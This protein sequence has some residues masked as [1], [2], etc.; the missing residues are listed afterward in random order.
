M[1]LY[2][3]K[4]I[5]DNKEI[6]KNYNKTTLQNHPIKNQEPNNK[7]LSNILCLKKRKHIYQEG[8]ILT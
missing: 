3:N 5:L 4:M 2:Q 6:M 8:E 7:F 1:N